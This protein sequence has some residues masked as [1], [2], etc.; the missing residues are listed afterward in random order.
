MHHLM[1]QNC[2]SYWYYSHY[3]FQPAMELNCHLDVMLERYLK[4]NIWSP[5][6][7]VSSLVNNS[8]LKFCGFF[9]FSCTKSDFPVCSSQKFFFL[10]F[11]AGNEFTFLQKNVFSIEIRQT[12][13]LVVVAVV[14][15]DWQ[16]FQSGK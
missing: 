7:T 4:H 13:S 11:G 9:N 6:L 2:Q 15:F 8:I 5:F 1:R 14:K 12:K 10:S 16:H 3:L